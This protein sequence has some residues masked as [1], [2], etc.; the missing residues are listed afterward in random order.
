MLTACTPRRSRRAGPADH[1]RLHRRA[2]EDGPARASRWIA[3]HPDADRARARAAR[4]VAELIERGPRDATSLDAALARLLADGRVQVITGAEGPRYVAL[5]F[6]VPLG[7]EAGW[8]AAVFDHLQAMVQ[9]ISQR[10]SPSFSAPSD[11]DMVGGSTYTFDVWPGHP[12]EQEFKDCLSQLR[13]RHTDLRTR[14]DAHNAKAGLPPTYRQVVVYGGQCVFERE[15]DEE[16]L[17]HTSSTQTNRGE[18]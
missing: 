4:G 15:I 12:L 6:H 10:L 3:A 18:S 11:Q 8:E 2:A 14:V 1:Q 13:T 16:S 17:A 5:H 7:A 9:T